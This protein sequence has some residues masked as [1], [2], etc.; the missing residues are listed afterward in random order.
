[1]NV[2][3]TLATC[4]HANVVGISAP[5]GTRV[6]MGFAMPCGCALRNLWGM[7]ASEPTPTVPSRWLPKARAMTFKR[8]VRP[9]A[10]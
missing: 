2:V 5:D 8:T 3:T 1:M 10:S 6:Q 7:I 4:P 9:F